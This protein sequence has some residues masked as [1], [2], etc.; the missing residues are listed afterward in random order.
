MIAKVVA[1][2]LNQSQGTAACSALTAQRHA[3][4]RKPET[5]TTSLLANAAELLWP[6][7]R[8]DFSKAPKCQP[9]VGGKHFSPIL[10]LFLQQWACVPAWT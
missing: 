5:A 2:D 7:I 3:R 6:T 10:Q 9:L 1:N 8:Q 4:L